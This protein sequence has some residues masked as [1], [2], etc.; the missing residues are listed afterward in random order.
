MTSCSRDNDAQAPVA[1]Y[2]LGSGELGIPVL[3]N[4]AENARVKLVGVGTQ[5]DRPA[6]RKRRLKATPLGDYAGTLGLRPDKPASVN[7][8]GFLEQI[9]ALAPELIVVVAFGQLLKEIL[10][11]LPTQGCLNVHAS[12]LPRHRGAAPINQAILAGDAKTGVSFMKMDRGLD[13]GPVYE[14]VEIGIGQAETA[15]QLEGRLAELA[16][17]HIVD[18]MW[19]VCRGGL[20][21]HSQPETG[22]TYAPKLK[23]QDGAIEW[24]S[25]A[26]HIERK[27]RALSPWPRAYCRVAIREK[28]KRLQ[29][30]AATV[31]DASN[32]AGIPPGTVLQADESGLVV[33]CGTGTLRVNRLIPEGRSEMSAADFLRGSPL[34]VSS[35]IL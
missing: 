13:T 10:L 17:A 33:A 28:E 32:A 23:K 2:F 8:S 29:L 12:L 31:I 11:N 9:R 30:T 5:P 18:C 15:D 24:P 16:G 14:Q 6:G 34:A 7:A 19:R 26:Q 20:S 35:V 27:I 1:A 3:R 21:E 25:E 4:M 22:V